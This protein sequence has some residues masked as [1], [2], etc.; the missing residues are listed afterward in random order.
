[1]KVW[2]ITSRTSDSA[3]VDVHSQAGLRNPPMSAKAYERL[4]SLI[5][6]HSR[7]HLGPSKVTLLT[8]RLGRHRRDL[9]LDSW[10]D[11]VDWL[12]QHRNKELET[13]IDL[14]STNHTHFFREAVH[15]D[16]LTST[17]LDRLLADSPSAK[18]GLRCWSAGCSSGEEPFTLAIVLSEY[19][20]RKQPG[21]RWQI[22]ATDISHRALHKAR[23]AVYD[24][25][26]LGLPDASWLRK[27]FQKGSGPYEGCC[28]V[29]DSLQQNVRF[30]RMNLFAEHYPITL[31]QHVIFCRNVLIYFETDAQ[32]QLVQRLHDSLEP[33]GLL[34]VGHSDSL[35]RI[36]HPLNSLGNGIYQRSP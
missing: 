2:T 31:P 1:M 35:L 14:V 3:M 13:L 29:K 26:R 27:Y 28:K 18:N 6:Q 7:M 32:T 36:K 24:I 17:L 12:E 23:Q 33:G 20:Q 34:I 25:D 30:R 21:L 11:Y 19:A 5:H 10:E 9:G 16:L 8:N 15:F 4:C 22:E